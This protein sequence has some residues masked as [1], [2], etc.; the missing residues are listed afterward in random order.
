M[1]TIPA[2]SVYKTCANGL[3]SWMN[4]VLAAATIGREGG[5][6]KLSSDALSAVQR[7]VLIIWHPST[8]SRSDHESKSFWHL[9][10]FCIV[11]Y[12][13]Q[14]NLTYQG[15]MA[16]CTWGLLMLVARIRARTRHFWLHT[17]FQPWR[18]KWQKFRNDYG[19]KMSSIW[20]VND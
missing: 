11:F 3:K 19:S 17:V 12:D 13:P 16:R 6:V 7:G 15:Q 14:W 9:V 18:Q 20:T 2:I 5:G 10:N 4:H 8:W 1:L